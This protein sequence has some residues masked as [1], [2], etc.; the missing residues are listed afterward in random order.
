MKNKELIKF[1]IEQLQLMQV[2]KEARRYSTDI[3][4]TAFLWQLTSCSLYKKLK[5][6]FLLPSVSKLRSYSACLSVKAGTLDMSYLKQ[7]AEHLD[8]RERLMTLMI[9]EVYTAKRTEYS[10]RT[11]VGVTEEEE[12]A[13]TVLAFMVQSICSKFKDVVCLVPVLKLDSTKLRYWFDKD[14]EAL[15]DLFSIVAVS[16]GNHVCNR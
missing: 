16:I 4:T 11:F 15:Q 2:K 14:M 5:G 10:N 9:D 6:M 7:R 8:E 3:I 13:K 12:P 1:I